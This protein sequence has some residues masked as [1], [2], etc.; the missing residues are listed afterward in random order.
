MV[1]CGADMENIP[2][3]FIVGDRVV[4]IGCDNGWHHPMFVRGCKG[5]IVQAF[6]YHKYALVLFDNG[7]KAELGWSNKY[8]EGN[9]E[10]S[11]HLNGVHLVEF[12]YMKP[13]VT[14]RSD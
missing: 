7:S 5:T 2:F 10:Y 3:K 9:A 6:H 4:M 12:R 8:W 11:E 1:W 13:L 14:L